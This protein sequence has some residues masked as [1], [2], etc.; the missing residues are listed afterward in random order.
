MRIAAIALLSL[1][2]ASQ[3]E[4]LKPTVSAWENGHRQAVLDELLEFLKIPN[5]AADKANIRRNADHA[6]GLLAKRGFE[7]ELLETSGN[8]LVF[9]SLAAPGATRTVLYCCPLRRAAGRSVGRS[10]RNPIPSRRSFAARALEARIYA[11]GR[12]P[13][14]KRRSSRCSRR[15]TPC[16]APTSRRRPI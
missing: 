7:T 12:R 4:G 10:G 8:P 11:R 2:L 3:T 16:A 13:T 15:S 6:R 14:T 9:G 5:V 1:A